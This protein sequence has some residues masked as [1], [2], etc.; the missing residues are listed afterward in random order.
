M[1]Q[2]NYNLVQTKTARA[3]FFFAKNEL[4]GVDDHHLGQAPHDPG[5]A[6]ERLRRPELHRPRPERLV[7]QRR[8]LQVRQK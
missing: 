6:D 2:T 5:G 8:L 7:A 3:E 1:Y 4:G